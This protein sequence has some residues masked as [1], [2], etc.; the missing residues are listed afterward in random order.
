[1][2]LTGR[3]ALLAALGSLPVGIVAPSWTGMLA[4]N[5]PLSLAILCDYAL[6]APV[7]SLQFTRSGDT[8]VRLG[9]QAEVQL[10]VINPSRSVCGH[11]SA[12]PGLRAVGSPEPAPPPPVT[13]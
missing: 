9:D 13:N 1:M 11:T 7:R 3:T 6:A 8:A 10:S 2:A 5:A 4:V 12:T